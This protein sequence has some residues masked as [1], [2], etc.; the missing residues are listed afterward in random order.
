MSEL[1]LD[2]RPEPRPLALPEHW[3]TARKTT[4]T[5]LA[6]GLL[7]GAYVALEAGSALSGSRD[8]VAAE[9]RSQHMQDLN[10]DPRFRATSITFRSGNMLG[11]G[12]IAKDGKGYKLVTVEHVAQPIYGTK[13]I[14]GKEHLSVGISFSDSDSKKPPENSMFI[15]GVGNFQIPKNSPRPSFFG[16]AKPDSPE[17]VVDRFTVVGLPPAIKTEVAKAEQDGQI[18]VPEIEPLNAKFGEEFW[19]PLEETGKKIPFI[20][21]QQSKLNENGGAIFAPLAIF[22]KK[23]NYQAAMKSLYQKIGVRMGFDERYVRKLPENLL[24]FNAF[25]VALEEAKKMRFK[26]QAEVDEMANRLPCAGDS[27]SPLLNKDGNIVAVISSITV[28]ENKTAGPFDQVSRN[29][30]IDPNRRCGYTATFLTP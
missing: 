4:A 15:P 1:P 20:Y 17:S 11:S 28:F 27:G 14:A 26:D 5:L 18:K 12:S 7:L 13:I 16:D 23:L 2:S 21:L 29:A 6:S 8:A 10:K 19:M 3:Y 9:I 24:S 25:Y 30:E 22:D